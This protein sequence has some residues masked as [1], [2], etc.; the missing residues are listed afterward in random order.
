VQA[1]K[2][3]KMRMCIA[4]AVMDA[5]GSDVMTLLFYIN[6]WHIQAANWGPEWD[7][8]FMKTSYVDCTAAK[9]LPQIFD[10]NP[11]KRG[12]PWKVRKQSRLGFQSHRKPEGSW[13]NGGQQAHKR[14]RLLEGTSP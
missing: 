14:S 3:T 12:N 7:E 8:N 1:R 5:S 2:K 9:W 4:S 13:G 6:L 10:G 11:Y